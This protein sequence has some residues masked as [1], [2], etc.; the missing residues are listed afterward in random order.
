M[1]TLS[2]FQGASEEELLRFLRR[3]APRLSTLRRVLVQPAGSSLL[4]VN[5]LSLDFPGIG[6]GHPLLVPL[7]REVGASFDP[8]SAMTPP[9]N[10]TQTR[11][12][13]ISARYPWAHDRIA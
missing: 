4:D 13:I 7:L 6:Y 3:E 11:D 8:E 1:R 5:R 9:P 10:D 2:V 12:F